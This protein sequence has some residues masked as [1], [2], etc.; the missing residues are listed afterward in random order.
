MLRYKRILC[1]RELDDH[2]GAVPLPVPERLGAFLARLPGTVSVSDETV[3]AP[4]THAHP[5][6]VVIVLRALQPER[7]PVPTPRHWELEVPLRVGLARRREP[8]LALDAHHCRHVYLLN[9]RTIIAEHGSPYPPLEGWRCF[10]SIRCHLALEP[11]HPH[12]KR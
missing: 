8:C 10:R 5:L 6:L 9:G 11:L 2:P 7:Q 1:L 4:L 12:A 3:L